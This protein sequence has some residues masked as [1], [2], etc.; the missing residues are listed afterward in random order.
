MS[1]SQSHSAIAQHALDMERAT[2]VGAGEISAA[3]E[4]TLSALRR[5]ISDALSTSNRL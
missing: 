1:R 3:V 4:S 5:P 2:G